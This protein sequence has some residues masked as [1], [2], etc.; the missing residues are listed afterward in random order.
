[1]LQAD[2]KFMYINIDIFRGPEQKMNNYF[3]IIGI[4][5]IFISILFSAQIVR[6][7]EY[8]YDDNG[9]ITQVEHEDGSS[10]V[11]S[12]DDNGNLLSVETVS[13]V[14]KE[15]QNNNNTNENQ[16]NNPSNNMEQKP[17]D[18]KEPNLPDN[19]EQKPSEVTDPNPSDIINSKPSD[20]ESLNKNDNQISE[21]KKENVDPANI[22][23]QESDKLDVKKT[24]KNSSTG[25]STPI[26]LLMI[27]M[28]I[29]LSAILVIRRR[30]R[31]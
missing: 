19:K 20:G 28:G 12:Y 2:I 16:G 27:L 29:S 25:D 26:I 23:S 6:A 8:T 11:Y 14:K 7:D 30:K 21:N 17:S 1:M 31:Y 18:N 15:N 22:E 13:P 24:D 9:R 5:L 4:A 10:T 3:K